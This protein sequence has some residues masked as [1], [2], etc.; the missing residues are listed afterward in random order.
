MKGATMNQRAVS[1]ICL[2]CG[3]E[4]SA[5]LAR[6]ASLRCHDCRH[7]EAPL[8]AELVSSRF[9]RPSQPRASLRPAA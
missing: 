4:L 9:S 8:R 2:S 6:S 3:D 5:V 7:A 1:R